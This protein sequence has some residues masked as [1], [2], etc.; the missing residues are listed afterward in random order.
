M[1]ILG[2][3][4]HRSAARPIRNLGPEKMFLGNEDARGLDPTHEL[5]HGEEDGVLGAQTLDVLRYLQFN[6]LIQGVQK[7]EFY[8]NPIIIFEAKELS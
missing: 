6:N 2:D 1:V 3:K 5:V 4:K 7:N 8:H